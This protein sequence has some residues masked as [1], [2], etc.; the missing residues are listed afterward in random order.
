MRKLFAYA[1]GVFAVATITACQPS[2]A[3]PAA[4]YQT[5]AIAMKAD[6]PTIPGE[7]DGRIKSLDA[8]L[9]N[10]ESQSRLP[11]LPLDSTVTIETAKFIGEHLAL[12]E[13]KNPQ[14]ETAYLQGVFLST[15]Y[16][17]TAAH[18]F[19]ELGDIYKDNK[20]NF[21]ADITNRSGNWTVTASNAK[22][23][24]V[25]RILF[26]PFADIALIGI[27]ARQSR[28]S[29]VKLVSQSALSKGERVYKTAAIANPSLWKGQ[30]DV[31]AQEGNVLETRNGLANNILDSITTTNIPFSGDSGA[32]LIR[33]DGSVVGLVQG[34]LFTKVSGNAPNTTSFKVSGMYAASADNLIGLAKA[35]RTRLSVC[36]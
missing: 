13:Y 15:D 9:S 27:D 31:I 33:S 5:T 25:T 2:A 22:L 16:V 29:G 26:D 10:F 24:D 6:C 8:I 19:A 14:G 4:P 23:Y 17:G 3:K 34:E 20:G 35:D 36:K 18:A 11:P 32:P 28:P 7:K 1:L 21:K 30:L 12:I